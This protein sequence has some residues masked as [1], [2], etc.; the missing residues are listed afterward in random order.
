[1][2][3]FTEFLAGLSTSYERAWYAFYGVAMEEIAEQGVHRT[4]I[5][6]RTLSHI[7]CARRPLSSADELLQALSVE[8]RDTE[9]VGPPSLIPSS[10][11][12]ILPT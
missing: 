4:T 10:F 11:L 12:A 9:L 8:D 1:M 5:V 2:S 7:F 6:K 3:S